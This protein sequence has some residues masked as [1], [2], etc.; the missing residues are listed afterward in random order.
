MVADR[1]HG[2]VLTPE[3]AKAVIGGH[4]YPMARN[5]V[6]NGPPDVIAY[7]CGYR[8]TRANSCQ[9]TQ[10]CMVIGQPLV[11]FVLEHNPLSS[12]RLTQLRGA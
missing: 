9:P 4:P 1:Y 3:Q 8:H 2:K 7:E 12:R 11:D 5:L 10:V 6:L